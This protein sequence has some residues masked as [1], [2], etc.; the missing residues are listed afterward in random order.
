MRNGHAASQ[1]ACQ[2]RL[3]LRSAN[4]LSGGVLQPRYIRDRH[5][6]R[7]MAAGSETLP[8]RGA[9]TSPTLAQRYRFTPADR[10]STPSPPTTRPVES[11]PSSLR[12]SVCSSRPLCRIQNCGG[13]QKAREA[14]RLTTHTSP[15]VLA[16]SQVVRDA[17]F[18]AP[19]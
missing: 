13:P 12:P 10:L 14:E 6:R 19:R 16:G 5:Q 1:R 11:S 7:Q 2:A 17:C 8:L 15:Q 9:R 3:R 4:E 18:A